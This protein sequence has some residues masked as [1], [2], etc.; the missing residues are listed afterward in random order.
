MAATVVWAV[1]QQH[2]A[3]VDRIHQFRAKG[4]WAR[5]GAKRTVIEDWRAPLH[6][7][8][9]YKNLLESSLTSNVEM[10]DLHHGKH[11]LRIKYAANGMALL[12]RYYTRQ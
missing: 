1:I 10:C 8:A 4:D 6:L 11:I 7:R 9:Y 12:D 3:C 2:S 5:R